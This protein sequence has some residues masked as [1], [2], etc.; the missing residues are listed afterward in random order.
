AW[1]GQKAAEEVKTWW[2]RDR[3]LLPMHI[4]LHE[5]NNLVGWPDEERPSRYL[6]FPWNWNKGK[7]ATAIKVELRPGAANTPEKKDLFLSV[8]GQTLGTTIK[9]VNASWRT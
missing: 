9:P 1:L 7:G 5:P 8:V 6:H 4:A 3:I 2:L